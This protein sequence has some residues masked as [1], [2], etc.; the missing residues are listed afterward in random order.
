MPYY[1]AMPRCPRAVL[2]AAAMLA[3]FALSAC[4]GSSYA[5]NEPERAPEAVVV[6][7]VK[8]CEMLVAAPRG[9]AQQKAA[10][11]RCVE[12]GDN[13]W[14]YQGN[15]TPVVLAPAADNQPGGGIAWHEAANHAGTVQRVCGPLA[16]S[17]NS[18]DDVFLNLG[19]DYPDPERFQIVLWDVGGVE[20]IPYGATLCTYGQ[21]TLYKGVAQIELETA[22]LV[23]IYE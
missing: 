22:S 3:A 12:I 11:L 13:V 8:A 7:P 21:I 20:P 10:E 17:G 19:R 23:Q 2:A 15:S 18:T 9:L 6:D 5:D 4:S 14:E 1:L 16:G